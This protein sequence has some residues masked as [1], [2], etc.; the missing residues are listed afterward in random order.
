MHRIL[1]TLGRDLRA[2]SLAALL[3]A[4][5]LFPP[6]AAA[7]PRVRE[8]ERERY[9][10]PHW[11]FDDRFHHDRYYPALGY[12]VS[13][14]PAG[15]L[16]VNYRSGR[17][18]F[19]S[20]VWYQQRGPGFVVVQP[21]MGVVA[22]VLPPAYSTVWV[23][24]VPYYYANDVYYRAAPG[25]YAVAQPPMGA[26]IEQPPPAPP[27]SMPAPVAQPAPPPPG[28]GAPPQALNWYYC[29]SARGYYPTV[30]ECRE[31]WR[32]VPASPAQNR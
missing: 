17:Y 24:G 30:P 10:T 32:A 9:Q 7:Q 19:H 12:S 3:A 31:G 23:A 18:F 14:L 15:N 6:G 26:M 20:G 5:L 13:I 25:G 4:P 21:P 16:A 2:A 11:V 28:V 8:H 1:I 22:P 27:A 29:E